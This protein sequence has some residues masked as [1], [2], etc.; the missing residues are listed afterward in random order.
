MA[1]TGKNKALVD[2]NN[3]R[4][5]LEQTVRG[6]IPHMVRAAKPPGM[7]QIDYERKAI[8]NARRE[9]Q[10]IIDS[11]T[12]LSPTQPGASAVSDLKISRHFSYLFPPSLK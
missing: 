4:Y 7:L 6:N 1:A 2:S 8:T 9:L 12:T 3:R 11:E 10:E 5:D